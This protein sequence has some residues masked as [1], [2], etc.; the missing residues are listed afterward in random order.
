[1]NSLIISGGGRNSEQS[2]VHCQFLSADEHYVPKGKI[3][4]KNTILPD[5]IRQ[6]ISERD[7]IRKTNPKDSSLTTL[8]NEINKLISDHKTNIWKE[9]LDKNWDH[10]NNSHML[11]N[12]ISALSNKKTK[13]SPNASI[14]FNEKIP[15]VTS[16][17][18]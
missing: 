10:K 18:R 15:F 7:S 4:T 8:N 13:S 6:K 16:T 14:K 11:W 2:A 3:K 1:M 12:T 5:P 17:N 9:K